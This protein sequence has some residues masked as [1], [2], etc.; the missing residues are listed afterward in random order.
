MPGLAHHRDP[1]HRPARRRLPDSIAGAVHVDLR[2]AAAERPARGH[3]RHRAGAGDVARSTPS[4][5]STRTSPT[6]PSS[7]RSTCSATSRAASRGASTWRRAR[8][9]GASRRPRSGRTPSTS[10]PSTSRATSA[11]RRPTPGA[12]SAIATHFLPGPEPGVDRLHAA[13]ETPLD[14]ATGG[15]TASTTRRHRLRRQRRRRD[16]RVLARPRAVRALRPAG[17]VRGAH[18]RR[19]HAA[20]HRDRRARSPS[21]RRPST[22]GRSSTR[23]TR[24]RRRPSLDRRP[25]NGS[26]ST[27]FEF[28]GTDDLTPPEL[29][30]FECRIDSTN[31]L[32]WQECVSPFNL[33]DLFTYEDV[34]M[35]PGPAHLRGA[36]HRHGR[37]PVREP[38]RPEPELR[39]Q[40]RPDAGHLHVDDDGRHDAAG[41]RDHLRPGER[42]DASAWPT[43]TSS[44][45]APTTP[46]RSL[47]LTLPVRRSTPSRG[48]STSN[49][50]PE[51]NCETP[52]QASG[53]AARR[54]HRPIRAIDLAGNVDPTPATRTWTV[55]PM[56]LTTITSG[57]G[58]AQLRGRAPEHERQRR[59][60]VRRRPAR[61]DV[62]VLARRRR[63]PASATSS[64]SCRAPRR[65]PTG[66]STT[67]STSSRS[68]PP[69]RRA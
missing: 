55:V 48:R 45:S 50:D 65:S 13:A 27:T 20:R 40:P 29:L 42:L 15:E 17:H 19:P 11:S 18:R 12:C 24:R 4:S 8:S 39:G 26:S 69:T 43:P 9:S 7:A 52:F 47:E 54:A 53:P 67:A 32:D 51:P 25:A 21:W 44:S 60:R 64:R 33:L 38:D 57:P 49:G 59:L 23:S 10:A 56:P 36:R 63:R 66:G 1:R 58:V 5:R 41:H 31:E 35:A 28:T 62:R 14:L 30:I 68:A 37:E 2:A 16:L 46:R 61:L 6:S 22:S 3:P 34:Q